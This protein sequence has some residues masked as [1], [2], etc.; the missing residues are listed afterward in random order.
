M[1]RSNA[2]EAWIFNS[3]DFDR[4]VTTLNLEPSYI[5]RRAVTII[6]TREQQRKE[7]D[8]RITSN[9][10]EAIAR[11]EV[12]ILDKPMHEMTVDELRSKIELMRGAR[13]ISASGPKTPRAE[14]TSKTPKASNIRDIDDIDDSTLL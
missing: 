7:S 14:R 6:K 4:I 10:V 11:D 2:S 13:S 9:G 3:P 5:R 1:L 12:R 8:M